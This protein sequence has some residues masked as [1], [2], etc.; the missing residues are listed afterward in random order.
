[1]CSE[2]N[3]AVR[4]TSI[5]GGLAAGHDLLENSTAEGGVL[6]DATEQKIIDIAVLIKEDIVPL[7]Y[8]DDWQLFLIHFMRVLANATADGTGDI[9]ADIKYWIDSIVADGKRIHG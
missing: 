2:A 9:I 8:S 7:H 3:K 1:M 4:L 6:L 5:V